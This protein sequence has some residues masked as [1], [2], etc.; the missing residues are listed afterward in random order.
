MRFS[1]LLLLV[2]EESAPNTQYMY[3]NNYND[4]MKP[5]GAL[6]SHFELP[7]LSFSHAIDTQ[8]ELMW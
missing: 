5:R 4:I 3:P 2:A 7:G 6:F 1:R 8:V